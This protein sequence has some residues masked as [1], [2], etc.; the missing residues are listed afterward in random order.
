MARD[1]QKDKSD[2]LTWS[3]LL[4]KLLLLMVVNLQMQTTKPYWGLSGY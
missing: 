1:C 4:Q 3:C 2:D